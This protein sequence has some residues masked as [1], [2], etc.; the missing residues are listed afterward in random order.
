MIRRSG[1]NILGY[2]LPT[3][4]AGP[5]NEGYGLIDFQTLA[6][7][8]QYRHTLAGDTDH[9]Q[10]SLGLSEAAQSWL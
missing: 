10:T 3:D 9:K 1:G 2:F 4:F 6:S 8:E 5:T 7:Y